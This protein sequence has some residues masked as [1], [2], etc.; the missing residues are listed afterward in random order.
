MNALK[1]E[2]ET[3]VHVCIVDAGS[4]AVKEDQKITE[5]NWLL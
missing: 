3:T 2:G 4:D 5:R 1:W